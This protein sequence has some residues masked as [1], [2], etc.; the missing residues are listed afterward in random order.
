MLGSSADRRSSGPFLVQPRVVLVFTGAVA[1]ATAL[2]HLV[3][4]V[5]IG[6][7]P[8]GLAVLLVILSQVWLVSLFF[9]WRGNRLAIGIAGLMAFAEFGNQASAHFAIGVFAVEFLVPSLGLGFAIDLLVLIV[10]C[11]LS[12]VSAVVCASSAFHRSRR[13]QSLPFLLLAL[14]G[15]S[16]SLLHAADDIGRHGFGSFSIEDGLMLTA[17]A[18]TVWILGALWMAGAPRIGAL[19]VM[20]ASGYIAASFVVFHLLPSGVTIDRIARTSGIGAAGIAAAT[21][22]IAGTSLIGAVVWLIAPLPG[23]AR[24]RLL[25]RRKTRD[26]E[27]RT[28]GR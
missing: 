6:E 28:V 2:I 5:Q 8:V 13:L 20:A 1:I 27:A 15:A 21:G 24:R 14:A 17:L 25:V 10:V 23:A 26:A 22:I 12:A 18:A 4:E 7:A 3:F 16:V 9:A 19:L 11:L